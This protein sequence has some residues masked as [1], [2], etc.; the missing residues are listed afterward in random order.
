MHRFNFIGH[1]AG[2][3]QS[4]A[5]GGARHHPRLGLGVVGAWVNLYPLTFTG[6]IAIAIMLG[7]GIGID[8]IG[9]EPDGK[10]L[11]SDTHLADLRTAGAGTRM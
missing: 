8:I 6:T 1:S 9:F 3:K 2:Y 11:L 4:H 5:R 10:K 7:I